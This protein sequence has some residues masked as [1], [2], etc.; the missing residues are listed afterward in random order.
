MRAGILK[1]LTATCLGGG[2]VLA[3]GVVLAA[4]H[5]SNRD[6]ATGPSLYLALGDSLAAGCTGATTTPYATACP[7]LGTS[8]GYVQDIVDA[9]K[10]RLTP[11]DLGCP[12]ET[13][14][15]MINGDICSYGAKGSFT[16]GGVPQLTAAEDF[17]S[18][19]K[20]KVRL[21][22]IDIGAND[23][24]PCVPP[25]SGT[26]IE[27]T[28]VVTATATASRNLAIIL[29][30]LRAADPR[31][32]IVGM[33]YYDPVLAAWLEGSVGQAVAA[34]STLYA[35]AFN[36]VLGVVYS[37]FGVSV[38]DVQGAFQTFVVYPYQTLPISS[39]TSVSVPQNVYD[40]CTLTYTC[41]S[42][43]GNPHANLFGYQVIAGAFLKAGAWPPAHPRGRLPW[44]GSSFST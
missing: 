34:E 4:S 26:S 9:A 42:G 29:T 36:R 1:L 19:N 8:A 37:E 28:C 39:T 25:S 31:A 17:L 43:G 18:S 40:I 21:V 15:T 5:A 10:M 24:L 44:A 7:P 3:P 22:T 6:R 20:R 23:L 30:G 2:L 27:P 16:S 11:T 38:A 14:T 35:A 32:H 13:T 33:N 12:G 41:A